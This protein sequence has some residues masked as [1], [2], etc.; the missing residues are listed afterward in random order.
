MINYESFLSVS[1]TRMQQSPIR[2]MGTVAAQNPDIISFAPGYPA[3]E[4]FAWDDYREI[5][6]SLL[7]GRQ[8][9]VLQ[10]GPTRGHKPLLE[11]LV[12]L[13]GARGIRTSTDDIIVTTGSQQGL[14]VIAR[15]L[16][17]PGDVALVELPSYAGAITAFR[18]V[19]ADLVGVRQDRAGVDLDHLDSLTDRLAREGR[20][21]KFLYVVP[22]FQNPTGQ[23]MSLA[24]RAALLEWAERRDML[25]VEDDPYGAL[26]FEGAATPAET[27]PIKADDANGRVLY[28]SSFSK[29]LAPAFRV[30]WVVAPPALASRIETAKQALD[31]C[32]GSFDQHMVYEACRRG[33]LDRHVPVLRAHYQHKCGVMERAL[34]DRLQGQAHWMPPRGG[35]FLWVELPEHIDAGRMLERCLRRGV[36]YVAGRAFF[37]DGSGAHTVRLAFSAASAD[38]IVEGINRMGEAFSEESAQPQAPVAVH[39]E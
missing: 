36:I 30:A 11:Y 17:D 14:D 32:T 26:Y 22:N 1:G 2:Q 20:R 13:V 15:L 35:F 33:V 23:L 39:Q 21:P 34:R 24:R 25:L 29:T 19:R 38:R 16:L 18:N 6:T 8:G 3:P 31:L 9:G 27:R 10:Y 28:L 4:A 37:V 7:T 12:S 5:A